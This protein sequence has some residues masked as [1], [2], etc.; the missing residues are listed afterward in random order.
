MEACEKG[1]YGLVVMVLLAML[2]FSLANPV[3]PV[4]AQESTP[5]AEATPETELGPQFVIYPKGSFDGDFFQLEI[6]AGRSQ[7]LT[8][9]LGNVDDEPL[10]L[11]TYVADVV[12]QTNGGFAI[13]RED[14]PL[15]GPASWVDYPLQEFA[16]EP[17]DGVER[18]FTVTIP[19]GTRPGQYV[20]GLAL[21]TAE[22]LAVEG[23]DLFTQT[24][25]KIV[26][27]F[28]TVPG[29]TEAAFELIDAELTAE[30]GSGIVEVTVE[31]G[32]DIL[33]RPQGELVLADEGGQVV[34]TAPVQMGSV[35]AGMAVSLVI[36]LT[37]ALPEGEYSLSLTLA[38]E[39]S[40][41]TAAIESQ[42]VSISS[43]A[44][45]AQQFSIAGEVSLQPADGEPVYA[46]IAVQVTNSGEAVNSSELVLDVVRNG[47]LVE[48][49]TLASSLA[50]PPGE[51]EVLQRYVPPTGFEAGEWSFV[52]RLNVVDP[53]SD[54]TTTVA[55]LEDIPPVTVP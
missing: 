51:T 16:F 29:P 39:E 49:F 20:A 48:S 22:P 1:R 54:A 36:P 23:T 18:T 7:D 43:E 9:V 19:E 17:G 47:E 41:A 44:Q 12:P 6:E 52:I 32:G 33:V 25:R 24:V 34:F 31:N 8:V 50:L 53:N 55:T 35:Y 37:T 42:A 38:D 10:E 2:F 3:L 13:A 15:T 5:S 14:V 45:A 26:Q 21:Q 40:G 46:D 4:N 27:V 30:G 11:V 28:I